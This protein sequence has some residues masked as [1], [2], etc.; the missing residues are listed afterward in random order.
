MLLGISQP[1]VSTIFTQENPPPH[2]T[3]WQKTKWYL[4]TEVSHFFNWLQTQAFPTGNATAS[5]AKIFSLP[6]VV[7]CNTLVQL[8]L[9]NE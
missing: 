3:F 9:P 7:C 2:A 6:H 1:T 5:I 4:V 8:C